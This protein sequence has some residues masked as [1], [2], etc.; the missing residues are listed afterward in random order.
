MRYQLLK[1]WNDVKSGG[2]RSILVVFALALGL[3]GAGSVAV[4]FRIQSP[5]LRRNFLGTE[6]PHAIITLESARSLDPR[7]LGPSVEA[8]EYRDFVLLRIEVKPNE[9]IP[10]WLF[11]VEDFAKAR[12]AKLQPQSGAFTPPAG[13]MVM[14]RDARLISDLDT[15]VAARV[16]SGSRNRLVR[17]SG[18][19]FDPAQAPATQDHFVYAYADQATWA[20][21]AGQES[22][23]RLILRFR[24]VRSAADVK[25]RIADLGLPA[26]AAVQIPA[27][28]QHPH[29]WQL[30]LL[31]GIIGSVGLLAFLMSSVLVSQV[32]EALL[33]GQIRQVGILKAI[34]ASR[35]RIFGLYSIYLL[36]FAV[37]SGA[38]AIPLSTLSGQAFAA[39]VAR[40]L[41]FDVLT[42]KVPAGTWVLLCGAALILPFLFA[43]PTLAKAGR[44]P[45]REALADARIVAPRT[46]TA[47]RLL[48]PP[49]SGSPS[50]P[51]PR[52]HRSHGL[53]SRHL[54]HRL[55]HE[56]KP[57]PIS[58]IFPGR[59]A[60]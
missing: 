42:R 39:F 54:R 60:V 32:I 35:S 26:S 10:L 18:V 22:G 37:L 55:Q 49:E 41:N 14:E 53:G 21:L 19:V 30:D 51:E 47:T 1:V 45:V 50:G 52:R 23:H 11:G 4:S 43:F 3:W 16:R 36:F 44:I 58:R 17:I 6:P 20:S 33:A 34:G 2:S 8:A 57:V 25:R 40:I 29:Q 13:T 46:R 9:W 12:L 15:G 56:G 5:D 7:S 59:H 27:F 38:L 24:D 28:E 31:L 48:G